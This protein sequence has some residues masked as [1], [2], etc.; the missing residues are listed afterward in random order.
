M[1]YN[2]LFILLLLCYCL[3]AEETIASLQ[4]KFKHLAKLQIN[5][6]N[7]VAPNEQFKLIVFNK[8][9]D[10]DIKTYTQI[11]NTNDTIQLPAGVWD[12]E[13]FYKFGYSTFKATYQIQQ[14]KAYEINVEFEIWFDLDF[15][16]LIA[17]QIF[18]KKWNLKDFS[19]AKAEDYELTRLSFYGLPLKGSFAPIHKVFLTNW[20]ITK[21]FGGQIWFCSRLPFLIEKNNN[22]FFNFPILQTLDANKTLTYYYHPSENKQNN[23]LYMRSLP[24]FQT[25]F[26][27]QEKYFSELAT[28]LVFN[29]IAGPLYSGLD[30]D[31]TIEADL[32]I[33]FNLLNMGYQMPAISSDYFAP[34]GYTNSWL[35]LPLKE[36][37]SI[38][39][40]FEKLKLGA[41]TMSN[42]PTL[43]FCIDSTLPGQYL[44]ADNNNHQMTIRSRV[45]PSTGDE[46]ER[47]EVFRNGEIIKNMKPLLV[48]NVFQVHFYHVFEKNY[49]WYLVRVKTKLGKIAITNP[50]YFLPDSYQPPAPA[51][52]LIRIALV[53]KEQN[54]IHQAKI[55]IKNG[56]KILAEEVLKENVFDKEVPITSH[57]TIQKEGYKEETF[58]LAENRKY[59]DIYQTLFVS[60]TGGPTKLADP[61]IF[62]QM[63]DELKLLFI[64]RT[65][66]K[67]SE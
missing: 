11:I 9:L 57:V 46:I 4:A 52:S 65:L 13:I 61:A 3:R 5:I 55:I 27:H 48:N 10:S 20:L 12:F 24:E 36:N 66:Q 1:K 64:N 37:S 49:A 16:E 15:S 44:I 17:G 7:Q 41:A 53:D 21:P 18:D 23:T 60:G 67:L 25:F 34:I 42:G 28:S 58:Y 14:K 40:K 22:T 29:T 56:D 47:F 45:D 19:Q 54:P 32:K 62:K 2:F 6:K 50:I 43:F 35:F 31:L 51:T 38:E 59:L 30:I 33:W 26:D 63:R 39:E 8:D